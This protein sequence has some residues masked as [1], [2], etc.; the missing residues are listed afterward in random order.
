[1]E[2]QH[3]ISQ[4]TAWHRLKRAARETA[5]RNKQPLC[6]AVIH[7]SRYEEPFL[8][9]FQ[10][11]YSSRGKFP[12]HILCTHDLVKRLLPGLPRKG[13]RAVTGYFGKS[14]SVHRRSL[15]HVGATA[16]IWHHLVETLKDSHGICTI[17]D[18]AEWLANTSPGSNLKNMREYPMDRELRLNLTEGPGIYKMHRS[19]GDI[20]YVG[21]ATSLKRRVNS[22]FQKRSRHSEHIL[23]MLSQ[24]KHITTEPTETA[25]EAAL[26]ETDEIKR[27]SPPYNIALQRKERQVVFF[28]KDLR[29][30]EEIPSQR[31]PIGPFS[32]PLFMASLAKM[33]ELLN[34]NQIQV[35]KPSI[36]EDILGSPEEYA[37]DKECFC[38][39]A[40]IFREE[41]IDQAK[42]QF[43]LSSFFK[44]G[45]LFWK[46][47]LDEMAALKLAIE[48]GSDEE[49]EKALE[50]E[51]EEATSDLPTWSPEKVARAFKSIVRTS[52]HQAQRARWFCRLSESTVV[53]D[54]KIK[55]GKE[56][57][58]I[59][60]EHGKIR[61]LGKL[62]CL[63]EIPI[64]PGFDKTNFER[65]EKLDLPAFDRMRILT[66]EMKRLLEEQRGLEVRLGPQITFK[67]EQLERILKWV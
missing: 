3:A 16:F 45:S 17:E 13:L 65:Q 35:A 48:E 46:E 26:I 23:E 58:V 39:G 36:I 41:F 55:K 50:L 14:L 20:L 28:S 66:T 10:E 56:R 25:L 51:V 37:P 32:T 64:P 27:L 67:K 24:A 6:H 52:A 1:D 31:H 57:R 22:Y 34:E 62:E 29:S 18:L 2:F 33:T 63:T 60:F 61:S 53:W 47:R 49:E 12:F 30:H 40:R 21:K 42:G 4:R 43:S 59:I 9:H 44:L 5:E 19:N 8:R 7:F 38:L 54:D 15:H 11:T